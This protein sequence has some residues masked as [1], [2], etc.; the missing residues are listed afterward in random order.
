MAITEA[1]ITEIEIRKIDGL[2]LTDFLA[3][4]I[5]GS[6]NAVAVCICIYELPPFL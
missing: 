1:V 3:E 4:V 5:M 2:T 6:I